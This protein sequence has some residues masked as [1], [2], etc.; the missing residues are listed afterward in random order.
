[1]KTALRL[2]NVV[3]NLDEGASVDKRTATVTVIQSSV[4]ISTMD[5]LTM[6]M[7]L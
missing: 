6:F 4:R 1:M 7:I 3:E 2:S 5:S